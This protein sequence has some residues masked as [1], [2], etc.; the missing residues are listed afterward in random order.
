MASLTV[1]ARYIKNVL[2]ELSKRVKS[3]E[4]SVA[5]RP[6]DEKISVE[7]PEPYDHSVFGPSGGVRKCLLPDP[8]QCGE[9]GIF[10]AVSGLPGKK[11]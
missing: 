10:L 1:E 5:D 6:D 3:V 4:R 8:D 9:I 7:I 11:K 2:A